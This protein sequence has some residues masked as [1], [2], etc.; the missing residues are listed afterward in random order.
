MEYLDTSIFNF[1]VNDLAKQAAKS[2]G[3]DSPEGIVKNI[4]KAYKSATGNN[5]KQT[6][7]ALEQSPII[8][9]A[10]AMDA[11]FSVFGISPVI[12]GAVALGAFLIFKAVRK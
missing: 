12:L 2:L 3:L 11:K 8:E 10:K 9:Q 5:T 4:G 6:P 7:P 1:D